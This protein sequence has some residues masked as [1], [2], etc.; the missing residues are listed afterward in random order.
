MLAPITVY[1]ARPV[2][3]GI[4]RIGASIMQKSVTKPAANRPTRQPVTKG[5]RVSPHVL[6]HVLKVV[7]STRPR[8][9]FEDY[10]QADWDEVRSLL[11]PKYR[12]LSNEQLKHQACNRR[13]QGV[14][15]SKSK[16][17]TAANWAVIKKAVRTYWSG[18]T[19]LEEL[20]DLLNKLKPAK[21][22]GGS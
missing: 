8:R 3:G 7:K 4:A 6:D 11:H 17:K 19:P 5:G 18:D 12:W 14:F 2:N 13:K 21:A 16:K 10:T 22:A 9:V 20:I 15:S 1:R